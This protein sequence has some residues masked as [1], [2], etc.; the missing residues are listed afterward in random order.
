MSRYMQGGGIRVNGNILV[1]IFKGYL[2]VCLF[3]GRENDLDLAVSNTKNYPKLPLLC[4]EEHG[5]KTISTKNSS[6]LRKNFFSNKTKIM[7]S[8]RQECEVL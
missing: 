2:Y 5:K 6:M 3:Y 7:S 4:Y 8:R 1:E